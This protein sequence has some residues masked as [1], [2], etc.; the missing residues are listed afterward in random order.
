MLYAQAEQSL[1]FTLGLEEEPVETPTIIEETTELEESIEDEDAVAEA[2]DIIDTEAEQLLLVLSKIDQCKLF[3]AHMEDYGVDRTFIHAI[4]AEKDIATIM[5]MELP[6]SENFNAYKHTI[7]LSKVCTEGLGDFLSKAWATVKRISSSIGGSIRNFLSAITSLFGN[8]E[9]KYAKIENRLA[10]S[11]DAPLKLGNRT[12]KC[13]KFTAEQYKKIIDY[14]ARLVPNIYQRFSQYARSNRNIDGN[15]NELQ[16][17]SEEVIQEL[18]KIATEIADKRKV[19]IN[20]VAA[21]TIS[22]GDISTMMDITK[23]LIG[24]INTIGNTISEIAVDI[25]SITDNLDDTTDTYR[26]EVLSYS[27]RVK[28]RISTVIKD[29]MKLGMRFV[30]ALISSLTIRV[31]KGTLINK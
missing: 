6:S 30:K 12:V 15:I 26:S 23:T 22:F 31:F 2:S 14:Y 1:R 7:N 13:N 8:L 11:V 4:Y 16:K 20:S 18:N 28:I 19:K 5:G 17:H 27:K 9:K 3:K 25:A 24:D 10:I 21:N 29:I